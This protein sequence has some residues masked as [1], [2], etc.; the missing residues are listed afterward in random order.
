MQRI[1]LASASPRRGEILQNFNISFE[2][3]PSGI[4][5][6]IHA[7]EEAEQIAM[8]LAFEKAMDIANQCKEGDIVIAADTVVVKGD[9]LGK[10][11]NYDDAFRMLKLLEND[12]HDVIT[13]LAV[14]QAH[15][16]NRIVA[17]EKTKVKMKPLTDEKINRY[18]ES[19]EVWDKAGA[20][21]IQGKGA[22]II[23]WIE[24]DYFN[25]VGLP[26]NKLESILSKKFGI[27]LI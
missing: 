10:P 25:V 12:I 6:K 27:E 9:I 23:E 26:V 19:G 8:A 4:V 7:G 20:Y 22:A 5:E 15:T 21:A 11:Q 18:I 14:V 2:I 17:Y 24:G 3:M 13:G 1:I 16:F